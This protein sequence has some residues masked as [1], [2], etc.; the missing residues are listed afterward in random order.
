MRS[1][2]HSSSDDKKDCSEI[3]FYL[4]WFIM[5]EWNEMNVH[6]MIKNNFLLLLFLQRQ[7]ATKQK[8]SFDLG[9]TENTS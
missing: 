7:I 6:Q 1:S 5:Q 2:S 9:K 4:Y 3:R 8:T